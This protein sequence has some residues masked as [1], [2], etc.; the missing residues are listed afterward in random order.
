M[1]SLKLLGVEVSHQTVYN[2]IN[3]HVASM[4]A[5]LD[6]LTPNV[7]DTWRADE[8]YVKIKGNNRAPKEGGEILRGVRVMCTYACI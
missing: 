3:K 5:Y 6:K 4:K 7:S 8:I 1:K 2:W